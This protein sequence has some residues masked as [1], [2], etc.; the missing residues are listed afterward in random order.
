MSIQ[1]VAW[2]LDHSESRGFARL[3]LIALAN[4]ANDSHECWPAQRT[5]AREAGMSP[6]SVPEQIRKLVDLGELEIVE[7]G[8][9]RR[10]ARYRLTFAQEMS[11]T[12][13]SRSGAERS[14]QSGLSRTVIEPS[15]RDLL[16]TVVDLGARRRDDVWDTLAELF[17][18]PTT[19][20]NRKLRGRVVRSLKQA[21]ATGEQIRLR[22]A[23]WPHHFDATLTETALEKHWDRLARPPA[24]LPAGALGQWQAE[25]ERALRAARAAELDAESRGLP[26]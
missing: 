18:E 21:G 5:L 15:K 19:E 2:V 9:A 7:A 4:H 14:A 10:S 24:R 1:A 3:V 13:E 16:P 22:C 20:S 26:G 6:G 23:A 17:G 11:E 25:Q 12:V 8:G